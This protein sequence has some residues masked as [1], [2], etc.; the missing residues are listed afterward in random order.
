M[1][2]PI[3]GSEIKI[4]GANPLVFIAGPCVIEGHEITL[5]IA[6]KLKK[7][8]STLSI[9]LIFKSSYDKANRTSINSYRGPGLVEGLRILDEVRVKY[10]LPVLS[11]IHRFE[12]IERAANV[13]DVLQ[14]PAFLCRQ[15]DFITE[16]ARTKKVVN[17][18]KGQF[19][20]PWDMKNV[21]EKI[22]SVDNNKIL[23]TER[24][25]SFGYNSLVAD[26]R[27]LPV[28]KTLGY[29]VVFDATHSVQLPGGKGKVSGG[30][31]EFV[32]YL[33]RAAV[34]VGID[35]I[36]MEVHEDPDRALCDGPNSIS[37]DSLPDLL[38]QIKKINDIVKDSVFR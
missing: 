29:P 35:A 23:L 21:I 16:I 34:A 33:S 18:K 4:G 26:M 5:R 25:T 2:T 31:R 19:L 20:A 24:G 30:Q 9:P 17:L 12:E 37:L 28:M 6:E 13:L 27:S 1:T 22:H 7:I 15:T 10:R 32:P 14:V 8:A 36:F 11:D 3:E 38:V